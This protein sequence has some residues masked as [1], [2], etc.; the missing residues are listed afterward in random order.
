MAAVVVAVLKVLMVAVVPQTAVLGAV[1]TAAPLL[2]VL[3]EQPILAA[4][5]VAVDT[6]QTH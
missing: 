2:T 5:V 3:T 6:Q 1:E 4:V